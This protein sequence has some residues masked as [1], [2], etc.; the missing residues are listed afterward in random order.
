MNHNAAPSHAQ[1]DNS[2]CS[3]A[4]LSVAVQA[5]LIISIRARRLHHPHPL[6]WCREMPPF[7]ETWHPDVYWWIYTHQALRLDWKESEHLLSYAIFHRQ[8]R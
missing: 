8:N 2:L 7:L 4:A 3:S 5:H 6:V 1:S